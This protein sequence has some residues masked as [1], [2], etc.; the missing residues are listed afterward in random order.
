MA[1]CPSVESGVV[2]E[3]VALLYLAKV[4][5]AVTA[6]DYRT[7][8]ASTTVSGT[9]VDNHNRCRASAGSSEEHQTERERLTAS[10]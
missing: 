10:T 8:W 4:V 2:A 6:S 1:C 5:T 9:A 3:T 7:E